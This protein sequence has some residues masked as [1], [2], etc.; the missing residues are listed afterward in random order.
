MKLRQL[1]YVIGSSIMTFLRVARHWIRTGQI[2]SGERDGQVRYEVCRG[3]NI[4]PLCPAYQP[5]LDLCTECWCVMGTK[6]KLI[7]ARCPLGK[8]PEP[9]KTPELRTCK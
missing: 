8:W 9:K 2:W 3:M 5:E 1:P 6:T 7:E 4:H